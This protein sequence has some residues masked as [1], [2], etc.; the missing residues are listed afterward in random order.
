MKTIILSYSYT[1][2]N[3]V[4]AKGIA[5]ELGVEHFKVSEPK[6]RTMFK[7]VLDIM[8]N[9]TPK[10]LPNP[11]EA[12][13]SDLIILVGPVWTGQ[14]ATPLR[15]YLK[16]LKSLQCKFAFISIS[17]GAEGGNPKLA[18]ELNKRTGRNPVALID[19]HISDLLPNNPKPSMKEVGAYRISDNDLKRLTN[20]SVKALK[21]AIGM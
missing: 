12:L 14:V 3:D 2:N 15:A 21:E 20:S 19:L 10:V 5:N 6:K 4:L 16:Q 17:G 8:F 11:V 18:A 1:G 13:K 7:I 9:R